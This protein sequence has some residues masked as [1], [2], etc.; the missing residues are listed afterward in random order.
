MPTQRSGPLLRPYGDRMRAGTRAPVRGSHARGNACTRTGIACARERVRPYGEGV[1]PYGDRGCGGGDRGGA[2]PGGVPGRRLYAQVE[3]FFEVPDAI[4]LD[5]IDQAVGIVAISKELADW[6]FLGHHCG[7]L[8][9]L[10][11][12]GT[13][14]LH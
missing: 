6:H 8:A 3:H 1:H 10:L 14:R 12:I 4:D 13:D 7:H 2:G 5:Q 11:D 9:E